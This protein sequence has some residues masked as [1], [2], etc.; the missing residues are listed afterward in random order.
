VTYVP[1]STR[2]N[3]QS[4]MVDLQ[5]FEFHGGASAGS[6][7]NHFKLRDPAHFPIW[8]AMLLTYMQSDEKIDLSCVFIKPP[9]LRPARG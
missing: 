1:N 2:F 8:V 9:P 4:D 6:R 5:G 7:F 3:P